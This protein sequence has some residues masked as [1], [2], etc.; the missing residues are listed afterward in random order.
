MSWHKGQECPKCPIRSF[1]EATHEGWKVL[2]LDGHADGFDPA[3]GDIEAGGGTELEKL[4]L[5]SR[6]TVVVPSPASETDIGRSCRHGEP[7]QQREV[8]VRLHQGPAVRRR[9]VGD[10]VV[11]EDAGDL[12]EMGKLLGR[13]TDM[14][15]HVV[16]DHDIEEK[17]RERQRG[18][19]DDDEAEALGDEARISDV[20]APHLT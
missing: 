4:N 14:L 18:A 2:D 13:W 8:E 11:L 10:S 16:R 17:V 20:N 15:D 3:V 19:L 9:K 6:E 5:A 12:S 7:T 1:R